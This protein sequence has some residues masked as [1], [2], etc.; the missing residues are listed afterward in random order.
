MAE[1]KVHRVAKYLGLSSDALIK[2][3]EELGIHA[4]GHMSTLA[5]EEIKK[6][7]SKISEEKKRV[8]KEFTRRYT[9]P[10]IKEKKKKI[11][12]EAIRE[13]V[14]S[15]LAKLEK[16]EPK[17]H[18]RR[19]AP[20]KIETQPDEKIVEIV[21]F[22]SVA[23]LA[24]ALKLPAGEVIKKC[25]DMGLM[26][27]LNQRLDLDTITVL[28]DEFSYNV[29]VISAEDQIT[30]TAAAEKSERPPVVTVMGHVDH[31]K[32]TLLD[33]IT[34]LKIAEA[35]Y[36][37]ITQR[38]AAYQVTYHGKAITFLDTPGHEAFTAM[39]ARGAQVTDIV[40]LVVAA[41]DGVMPQTVEAIDHAL[42][43]SLPIIV[44]VNK[45]DLPDANPNR[46]KTELAKANVVVEDF[47]GKSICVE[48]SALKGKGISDILDAILVKAEELQ[49]SAPVESLAK[50]VVIE[51]RL[52][53]GKGNIA[54][55]LVQEGSLHKGDP[56]VCGAHFGRV[57]E[58]LNENMQRI[59][60]AFPSTPALVVGFSG[61]P[62]AGEVFLAT[63]NERRARELAY[64]RE[65]M[66]RNRKLTAKSKLTL[67]DLQEKIKTGESKELR[68][69]IKADSAG[70]VEALDEK[71][72]EQSMDDVVIKV[73]HKGVGKINVSDILLAEVTG[74]ICVG[75]HVGPD[76]NG[77]DAAER[78]GVEIRTYRLI[79]E[80][81]DDLRSAML[82]MLE[83]KLQEILIGEAEVRDIFKLPKSV[84][85]LGCYLKD[86]KIIRNAVAH[87]VRDGKEILTTKIISLKR[88]K[89]DVKEVVSG[90]E[91]GIILE[92]A[93]DVTVGDIIQFYKI[94]E[95][96]QNE[97]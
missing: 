16:K 51:A 38:M 75:F 87:L 64:Q 31:G 13:T 50:G 45:I 17:K 43:A 84:I 57:R 40:V 37:R 90:Y 29:K 25:M 14:K 7:K 6:V 76:A 72:N 39:R 92:N 9:K 60:K 59:E 48:T 63:D 82:G 32:T 35:E 2:L 4:K 24:Q 10:K 74:S 91:C 78:E 94:E 80:A 3:L 67:L 93:G 71:L 61:L 27:S 97:G 88:F 49:L 89:D 95:V 52:D 19:E 79:Y 30:S 15:T 36:G 54:T 23:E 70:S 56:F 96:S 68:L 18:Y 53:R 8:K 26:A 73:V 46:V 55:V 5:D 42:A 20:V 85:A 21:E 66:E 11:D 34:K 33:A 41:D 69:V 58:L 28:C 12:K 86:G 65:L 83:P 44:C 81:L 62:Q 1:K 22:M 47:G 77:L